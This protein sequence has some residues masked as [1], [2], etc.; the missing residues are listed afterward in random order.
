MR[1]LDVE[2]V[3]W[4]N[5]AKRSAMAWSVLAAEFSNLGDDG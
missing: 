5:C 3:V 1:W 2:Y 4:K